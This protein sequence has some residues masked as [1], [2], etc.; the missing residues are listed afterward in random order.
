MA[1]ITGE[2][3]MVLGAVGAALAVAW[4]TGMPRRLGFVH[5]LVS[6]RRR[7]EGLVEWLAGVKP[8]AAMDEG[9]GELPRV[10][11][12][13]RLANATRQ[14]L[15]NNAEASVIRATLEVEAEQWVLRRRVYRVAAS[16]GAGA[17]PL[18]V[19]GATATR[20]MSSVATAIP[21]LGPWLLIVGAG[22]Y[23]AMIAWMVGT[24]L[25][26]GRRQERQLHRDVELISRGVE[27]MTAGVGAAGVREGLAAYLVQ[28]GQS[29]E[30]DQASRR[31][32]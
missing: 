8:G 7:T 22:T 20:A 27:L 12:G 4:G 13:D 3:V 21:W 2:M 30:S 24:M 31:A 29:A 10:L 23:L 32:A 19:A 1:G 5:C 14:L 18:V 25:S 17:F 28:P 6:Q 16:V 26:G 11:R 15:R 9:L